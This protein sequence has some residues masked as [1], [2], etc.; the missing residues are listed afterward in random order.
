MICLGL[1]A[2]GQSPG[3]GLADDSGVLWRLAEPNP[4]SRAQA[5][6]VYLDQAKRDG[7][8]DLGRLDRLAVTVGP[9]SFTGL[10]VGLA[11]AKGLAFSLNL[12]IVPVSSLAAIAWAAAEKYDSGLICP[13]LD[14]RRKLIYTALFR[15][16]P[17]GPER[18]SPDQAAD[19]T[20]WADRLSQDCA[21][22][23]VVCGEGLTTYQA[24]F[25]DRLGPAGQIAS[26]DLWAIDPGW[27][28]RLGLV[29]SAA[30]QAK[31][32]HTI[33]ANY[34][35]PVDAIRPKRTLVRL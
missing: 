6:F 22:P 32:A 26:P 35:R 29:K 7:R 25:R 23:I 28:A 8:L 20:A 11:A 13:V 12:P 34:I 17:A 15:L 33:A 2:A 5:L 1:E 21:E 18:L 16:T 4:P 31:T 10:K 27:V 14:A 19:P 30:G 24:L 3:L 9:G